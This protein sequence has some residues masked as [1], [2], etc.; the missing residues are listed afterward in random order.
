MLEYGRAEG[1]T[2]SVTPSSSLNLFSSLAALETIVS[3]VPTEM[4][5]LMGAAAMIS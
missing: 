1:A 4:V 3:M 5:I 2:P